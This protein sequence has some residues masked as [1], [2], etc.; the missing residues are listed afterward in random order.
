MAYLLHHLLEN[1]AMAYP[2]KEAVVD[3]ERRFRYRDLAAAARTCAAVL[4]AHGLKR[5]D[6]V[7][8]FLDKSFEEAAVIFGSSLAGGVFVPINA[9]LRPKQ[10]LHII[11]DCRV[12]FL[13]TSAR[14]VELLRDV[15]EHAASV[16]RIFVVDH[17]AAASQDE[18]LVSAAFARPLAS[19]APP[20]TVGEDLAAILY[21]SGSTGRPKGVMVSHRNLLAG[22]RIVCTYLAIG[23]DERILS[24]LP[25]SFDYGL[26]QLITAVEQGATTILLSF[27][28]ADE[29]VRAIR[30]EHVTGVAGVPTVWAILTQTAPGFHREPLQSLRYLTNS[31]GA[32]P[33][34]TLAKLRAAQP[35]VE[36]FL[37]YGFTEAFRSTYLPPGELATRPTSIGKA[38]PETEILLVSDDGRLCAPGEVG[39]LV[40]HGPTV[41][42]GYWGRP[43]ETAALL[44]P[45]PLVRPEEGG[46]LVCYSGDRVRMDEQGYFYFVGRD[47]MMIKSAG[48]R[49]SPSEVEEVLTSTGLV[50]QA[51]VF[52]LPD[53]T[54]GERICAICVAADGR[55]GDPSAILAHCATELPAHMIP[56]DLQFVT[57]LPLSPNGKVDYQALKAARLGSMSNC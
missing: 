57:Q 10:V 35:H 13:V 1:T 30:A 23:H 8:V 43:V 52:G 19:P 2:D 18:R 15:L 51:A 53:R 39:I 6:R 50:A 56:R 45:H 21:T 27:R 14:R 54:L 11:E 24:I 41:A 46:P 16:D 47:D 33:S 20:A 40:H 31:G 36:V 48:Y 42:L 3:G 17:A 7:G 32:V 44:R 12:R 37:M 9:L 38:V 25:F 34:E 28:F 49:I 29:I 4:H 22:S 26:N 5:R 55:D